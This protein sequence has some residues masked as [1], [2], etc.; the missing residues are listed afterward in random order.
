ME[1]GLFGTN[2]AENPK[3]RTNFPVYRQRF[4]PLFR[5]MVQPVRDA[6]VNVQ[7]VFRFRVSDFYGI[8]LY[9]LWLATFLALL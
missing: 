7:S 5:T 2:P 6:I 4:T 3:T 9:V 8:R 1:R